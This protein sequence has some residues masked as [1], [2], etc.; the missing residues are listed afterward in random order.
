MANK[1]QILAAAEADIDNAF[2]CYERQSTG[3]VF[4]FILFGR[5]DNVLRCLS[6]FS[7]SC[8][9]ATGVYLI[10]RKWNATIGADV[11]AIVS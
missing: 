2:A 3:L 7:R 1:L 9:M 5:R 10:G 11:A 6:H 8:E 4:E